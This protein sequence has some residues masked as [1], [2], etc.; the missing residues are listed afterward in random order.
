M[1]RFEPFISFPDQSASFTY[2]VEYGRLLQ[3]FEQ[4]DNVVTNNGLPIR[5]ENLALLKTTAEKYGYIVAHSTFDFEGWV[6]FRA[7]KGL[8]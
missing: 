8:N 2:G 3:K 1:P 5:E 7:I 6:N 4:G